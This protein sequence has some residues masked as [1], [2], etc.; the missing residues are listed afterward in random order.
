MPVQ[1]L[2]D[3][4]TARFTAVLSDLHLCE[5]E[6]V[7]KKYPLW[8]K[9]KTREFFFDQIFRQFLEEIH[10]KSGG[11][12]IELILNGDIFDFDSVC[13]VPDKPSFRVDSI[14][15][16]RG[17]FAEEEK[18]VFKINVILDDHA[19][20][21][22]ALAWFLRQGHRA[23]FVI[24]NHDLELF[25][26]S[27]QETIIKRLNLTIEE[28]QNVRF[29]ELF[30]VSNGDTL[31]EHGHQYDPYCVCEDQIYPFSLRYNRIEVRIPFGNLACRYMINGM[32]FF[33]PYIE[34][35]YIMS[36][37]EY[38]VFFFRYMAGAQPL[39]II[40]W[41]WGATLTLFHT[42]RDRF[43]PPLKDPLLVEARIEDIAAKANATPRMVREMR[44]LAVPSA[45][46]NPMQ[47]AR[48]LW[49]DRA[50]LVL[51]LLVLGLQAALLVS[52]L[53][54]VSIFWMFIPLLLF[55]PF[56]IFYSRTIDSRVASYKEPRERVL[57]F[58]SAITKTQRVIY[59]HT[60]IL[61]HEII[62]PVEHMNPGTWSPAFHDV[63]C[64]KM[65]DQKTFVWI[66][67]DAQTGKRKADIYQ[68]VDGRAELF[69]RRKRHSHEKFINSPEK[70]EET[71]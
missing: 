21:V 52:H 18:S 55:V 2:K 66:Q 41:L 32:G 20:W 63:E 33:N 56:F 45:G 57:A 60:H 47:I 23:V 59:G 40:T 69:F 6:P 70:I 53:Y 71:A 68:M 5:E 58:S 1:N 37:K 61:R 65:L 35:N 10:K 12:P 51:I 16:T 15:R 9:Y 13:K 7:N 28:R 19:E 8:K 3:F 14:E 49:L 42:L 38:V 54:K 43:R 27:V 29:C 67:P 64:K 46:T 30:Y 25:W 34:S 22:S 24:G 39:L 26:P 50:F 62:G 11:E 4:S 36:I 48:E 17:L 44:E 31:I